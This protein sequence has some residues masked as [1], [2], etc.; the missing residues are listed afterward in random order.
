MKTSKYVSNCD[1]CNMM[2]TEAD[3]AK[4]PR[5][6]RSWDPVTGDVTKEGNA[7]MTPPIMKG[8]F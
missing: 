3:N 1:L 7:A 2:L 6:G 8:D 4:C 5:C